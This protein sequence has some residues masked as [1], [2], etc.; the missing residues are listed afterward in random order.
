MN[1]SAQW[2][3]FH[4]PEMKG[5][6]FLGETTAGHNAD[7]RLFQQFGNVERVRRHISELEYKW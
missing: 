2:L 4:L 7:A 6:G 3:D 5:T 1:E